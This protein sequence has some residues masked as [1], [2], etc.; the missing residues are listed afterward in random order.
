MEK[1][2]ASIGDQAKNLKY[3][4]HI[5]IEKLKQAI[6]NNYN[7]LLMIVEEYYYMFNLKFNV[8]GFFLIYF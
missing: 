7:F 2:F 4:Y 5:R 6:E 8:L 3:D 1:N